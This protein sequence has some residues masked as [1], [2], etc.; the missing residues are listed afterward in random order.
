MQHDWLPQF[1]KA[2][3]IFSAM[4]VAEVVVLVSALTDQPSG[5]FWRQIGIATLFT[6]ILIPVIYSL[7]APLTKPRAHAGVRLDRELREAD[8]DGLQPGDALLFAHGFNIHFGAIEAPGN[9]DVIM[10]APKS[11]G[12]LVRR[13][14]QQGRGVPCLRAVYQDA[15][16][17]A[18]ERALRKAQ[19][20]ALKAQRREGEVRPATWAAFVLSR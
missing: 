8:I 9:I 6:L 2:N 20:R 3:F 18:A 12:D 11:P 1:C 19:L 10:V 13:Q 5:G 17:E 15:S 7:L 14:F 4:V 16:G